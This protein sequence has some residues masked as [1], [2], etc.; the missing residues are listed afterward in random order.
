MAEARRTFDTSV[1]RL[2]GIFQ[3]L[4]RCAS[5]PEAL[6]KVAQQ[7]DSF[8]A[9]ALSFVEQYRTVSQIWVNDIQRLVTLVNEL[10]GELQAASGKIQQRL[11][12]LDQQR[13]RLS[14]L[15]SEQEALE[16]L[17]Q[18][19][20]PTL[21]AERQ[22]WSDFW[23]TIPEY[24]RPLAPPEG[25]FALTFLEAVEKQFNAWA[26]ELARVEYMAHCYDRLIADW[27][28]DLHNLSEVET[29]ELQEV[30]IKN[31][32]VIGIT[33][34]QAPKLTPRELRTFASFDTIIIDEVSKATAPE[35]LLPAIK[36]KKLILI[37]DQH[38]L[39]PMIE[40]KT[41]VQMAEEAGQDS[42]VYRFLNRSYFK[43][44]YNE[45]PD[46]IKRMLSIQYRMHPDIMAAINQ[47]YE[48]PLECG[49]NQ[50]DSE[51]DHQ[52]EIGS[53]A[54]KQASDLGHNSPRF[55]ACTK[56]AFPNDPGQE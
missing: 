24:L 15:R 31:A 13:R 14:E 6:R 20:S 34:G 53:R 33:C 26:S 10:W 51:R 12:Q 35:L 54:Q 43:E 48:C 3:E 11:A 52:L 22:W 19:D 55:W 49:L 30:Y 45:A 9:N 18:S 40:D 37:G 8:A 27:V 42:Q 5:I 1:Q 21:L 38:Q 46:T 32:N 47:F 25:I 41:L 4:S 7:N 56:A 44:R 29:R 39:P 17:L 36:G 23:E 50:P 2:N 28:A 16:V